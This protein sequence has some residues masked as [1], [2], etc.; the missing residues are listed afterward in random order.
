MTPAEQRMNKI[1]LFLYVIV[2]ISSL[3]TSFK[4]W[5]YET[6]QSSNATFAIFWSNSATPLLCNWLH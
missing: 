2:N 5:K 6:F 1:C 3:T 4:R